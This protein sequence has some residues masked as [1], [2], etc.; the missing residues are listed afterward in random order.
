[1]YALDRHTLGLMSAYIVV[2]HIQF[3]YLKVACRLECARVSKALC[4]EL[5]KEW[6]KGS[7][8]TG[9]WIMHNNY[10]SISME[11]VHEIESEP[12]YAE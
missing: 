11:N 9:V 6:G 7:D 4:R 3:V 8:A 2:M 10:S 1:M 12:L 5:I